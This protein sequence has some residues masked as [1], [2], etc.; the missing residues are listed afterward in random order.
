MCNGK[1]FR[2]HLRKNYDKMKI[3]ELYNSLQ[4]KIWSFKF[5]Q[6]LLI[7]SLFCVLRNRN[8]KSESPVK[9][10]EK[11]SNFIVKWWKNCKFCRTWAQLRGKTS[12]ISWRHNSISQVFAAKAGKLAIPWRQNNG[13]MAERDRSHV[14]GV[15]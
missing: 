9:L 15:W 13:K 6:K 10:R 2:E 11:I 4:Q 12:C 3:F 7:E 14:I 5:Y 8:K 1:W